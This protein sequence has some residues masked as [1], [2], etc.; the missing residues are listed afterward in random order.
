MTFTHLAL[1]AAVSLLALP[2][3]AAPVIDV[4]PVAVTAK[5]SAL[6][7]DW[8]RSAS[9]MEIFVRSYKDSDGDGIGDFNGLTQKL[10][11]LHDLGVTGIWLMPMM[12]SEDGDHGY[13]VND[14]RAVNPDYGTMADFERFVQEAHKRG[15]G[16]IIDY[17]VNHSG[18]G[19]AL[20]QAAAVSKTSPYRDWYVFSDQNPGWYNA[21]MRGVSGA[22]Y[23]DPWKPVSR[24][25]PGGVGQ[26]Y[27]VF[28]DSMPDLNLKNPKVIAY[29]QDTMRFWMNK[30]V[31][32]FRLDA[33]TM[34]IEDGKDRYFNNPANPGIVAKLRETLDAY[35]NRYMICEAS[36][37]AEM[38]VK[39]C[40]AFAYGVQ[41]S[42]IDSARKGSLQTPLSAQLAN[43]HADLMPLAL[44]SH[45]S[46]VGDRLIN[47]FGVNNPADYKLSA[48]IAILASSTPFGYYGEEIGM[49][50]GGVFNDPGI[51]SPMSWTGYPRTAGFT[52]GKPY[53]DVAI[54]VAS[55]NVAAE[56]GDP[57]S[58]LEYYRALYQVRR[59]RPVFGTG[60]LEVQSKAGDPVLSFTRT[61]DTDQVAVVI[62]L[63][64]KPQTVSLRVGAGTYQQV[65]RGVGEAA[66]APVS[67][68]NGTLGTTIPAK[69][70]YVFARQ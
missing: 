17:V 64:D 14:Y 43:P 48:A 28:S 69:T 58:L 27:G 67:T 31:D 62:N 21:K 46:Y 30:G 13:A 70:S 22:F 36:E 54:N 66:M 56:A 49:S 19:N 12:P 51:R 26:Y 52:T 35:D 41:A 37:G 24:T 29:L 59:D 18:S 40:S 38:Y 8:N 53:R 65:L 2:A 7:K 23:N 50:N 55:H 44:Q 63:S 1:A 16:V 47:Q 4:S 60:V 57:A 68:A 9:F 11:Y 61:N 20:F 34:L 45:D 15:I 6:P 25:V 33:V 39:A 42:I 3:M 32:G 5:A 10:D